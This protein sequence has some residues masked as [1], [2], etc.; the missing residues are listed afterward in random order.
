M[1]PSENILKDLV[2]K[3]YAPVYFLMGDEPF[4]IDEVARFIEENILDEAEKS[5]NQTILY[6]RDISMEDLMANAK[7]YPMMAEHQ[8]VI[9]REAQHLSKNIEQLADY[10]ENP[11]PTTLLVIL[12]K[13][14]TLDKRK[15]LYKALQQKGVL[16]DSKKLYENQVPG[17]INAHLKQK[18]FSILPKANA[19]LVEFLG[20]DLSR[21]NNALE[22]LFLHLKP[23]QA[24]TPELIEAHIGISKDFNNFELRNAI[25]QRDFKKATQIISHFSQN[26]KDNPIVVTISLL[27][28]FFAQLLQYHGLSDHSPKSVA[29]TL[30]INPYFVDEYKTAAR[31]YPMKSISPKIALLRKLDMQ[32]KGLGA[33]QTDQSEL[34]KELLTRLMA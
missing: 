32:S 34:L 13:Y 15:K 9:V 12:Y 4:F 6:G 20:N 27:Y 21:I 16:L 7:R 3:K 33:G 28:G 10:V 8:V 24:I 25:G 1:H 22:K 2:Q 29:S 23:G 18:N 17:W 14:K 30:K 11:L 5:F 26:P 31:N 19:L